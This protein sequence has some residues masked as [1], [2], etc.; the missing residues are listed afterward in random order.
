MLRNHSVARS[1]Q[2]AAWGGFWGKVESKAVTAAST[3]TQKVPAQYTTQECSRCQSRRKVA[4]SERTFQCLSCGHP[5]DR[6]HNSS[7]T[8][9]QK[10]LKA[11]N[12]KVGVGMDVPEFTPVETGPLPPDSGMTAASLVVES[13]NKFPVRGRTSEP[14][15]AG[16]EEGIT[17]REAQKLQLWEDVTTEHG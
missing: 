15:P 5:D 11:Y 8:I 17:H 3:V 2:D 16:G 4:L 7:E 13:G 10:A 9:L 12:E 14:A 1:I 6:D